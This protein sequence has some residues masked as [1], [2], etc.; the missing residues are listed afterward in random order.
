MIHSLRFRL[1]AAFMLVIMAAIGTISFFVSRSALGEIQQFEAHYE[2]VQASR[3]GYLLGRFF[4]ANRGDWTG[5]QTLVEQVA[6]NEGQRLVLVNTSGLVV[7]DSQGELVGKQYSPAQRAVAVML[8]PGVGTLYVSPLSGSGAYGLSDTISQSLLW[9]GL[10][11]V[12]VALLLTFVLWRRISRPIQA[13]TV[14][15]RRLGKGDFSHRVQVTDRGEFGELART[16]NSMA[17]DLERTE[18]LRRNMVADCAHE[19]RTPLTNIRGYLEAVTDGIVEPD[20]ATVKTLNE[21]VALLSRIV[22]DLQELSLA[23]AGELRLVRQPEDVGELISRVVDG[24]R[25]RAASKEVSL[26]IQSPGILP[27]CN[28]DSQRI[29]QVLHNLL[30]NALAHTP[31][32]GRVTVTAS[33]KNGQIEISVRDTG[34]GIPAEELPNIFERFYRVDKSRARVTGG[35]GLGLTITKRLVEAHGGTIDVQ[36]QLGKGSCFTFT[37]PIEQ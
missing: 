5:V 30:S 28:V 13:L 18:K 3:V 33:Q 36:S 35:S 32:S 16:F 7:S 29:S 27:L 34:E 26:E 10:L 8:P 24:M 25:A 9:G 37:L 31:K 15:A 17:T 23:D 4:F 20:A 6:T 11:A 22:D 1:L 21:E 2:E 14:G 19:L 12:A